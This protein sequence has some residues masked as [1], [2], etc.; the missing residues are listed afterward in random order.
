MFDS[1]R[2]ACEVRTSRCSLKRRSV[3][4]AAVVAGLWAADATAQTMPA[5]GP[6]LATAQTMPARGPALATAPASQPSQP[7]PESARQAIAAKRYADAV[8]ILEPLAQPESAGY[9]VV[10]NLAGAYDALALEAANETGPEGR[11]HFE[12]CKKKAVQYYV[13]AG[14]LAIERGDPRSESILRHVLRYDPQNAVALV[15]LARAF[16]K[17]G[18][19]AMAIYY[20]REY[21]KTPQGQTDNAAQVELGRQLVNGGFW[22]QAV[23]VLEKARLV[24]GADAEQQLARA[25]LAGREPDKALDAANKAVS[26]AQH[27]AEAFV[28]RAEVLLQLGDRSDPRQAVEDALMALGLAR[29]ALSVTPADDELWQKVAFWQQSLRKLVDGIE[30]LTRTTPLD[31]A[32]QIRLAQLISELGDLT[33][34]LHDHEAVLLLS[35]AA[36]AENAPVDLL[37]A[38]AQRQ[39]DLGQAQAAVQTAERILESDPNNL[40]AQKIKET[41]G[42]PETK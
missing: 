17:A 23:T 40:V 13:R 28:I 21:V 22:H 5:S 8:A 35:I 32:F 29:D 30:G 2:R 1:S 27:T 39:R 42:K 38:L 4:F 16:Q 34:R 31:P 20:Y 9:D 26:N 18:S 15:N 19:P 6:A 36:R 24:G 37:V 3:A 7:M 41:G 12:E 33:R 11:K 14:K 10:L 25:Y